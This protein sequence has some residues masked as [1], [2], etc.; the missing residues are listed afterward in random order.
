MPL[1]NRKCLFEEHKG[2]FGC[3]SKEDFDIVRECFPI[4]SL[5]GKV[6]DLACGSGELGNRL[7]SLLPDLSTI[8]ADISLNLLKWADFPICQ[9]DALNLPFKD[10]SFDCIVAGA[11]FH[12]F[13]CIKKAISECS[14]CL[15]SEGFF[16]AYDPNKL[17]PQRFIMMTY[18]LRHIFYRSGDHAI[19]PGRFKNLLTKNGFKEIKLKYVALEATNPG[20]LAKLNHKL[21]LELK[22]LKLKSILL[23]TIAPWFVI[24]AIKT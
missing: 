1:F 15:K 3:I 8:G 23:P 18:P 9:S 19:F 5:N 21:F 2:P 20:L 4:H 14:R 13:P 22:N 24:S 11:A 17:H 7:K 6:L 10:N 12:H 16:L